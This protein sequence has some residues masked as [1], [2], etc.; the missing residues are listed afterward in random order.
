VRDALVSLD[1]RIAPLAR[2]A[3]ELGNPTWG[4]LM[5]AGNDKS[6]YARQ[7]E[8]Y[9]DVYLSRVSNFLYETPFGFLRA[10]RPSLPHDPA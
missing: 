9:A 10:A 4:S 6:L 3:G 7:V 5:R 2:A 1:E 8:R